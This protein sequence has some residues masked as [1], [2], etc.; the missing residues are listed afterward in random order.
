MVDCRFVGALL[1][2]LAAA[3][4]RAAD[5][6]SATATS[7][8]GVAPAQSV[9]KAAPE[10]AGPRPERIRRPVRETESMASDV[11]GCI[12]I[13]PINK[14]KP[15]M[16]AMLFVPRYY[17]PGRS[18]PLLVE[19]AE[20]G[21]LGRAARGFVEQAESRGFLILAMECSFIRQDAPGAEVVSRE[22]VWNREGGGIVS[23]LGR[24][25]AEFDKDL[26]VDSQAAVELVKQA[27]ARYNVARQGV[28]ITGFVGTALLAYR[29][30][31]EHPEVFRAV[32]ARTGD[33]E[34]VYM[35]GDIGRHI[36]TAIYI[37]YGAN[38][39][40]KYSDRAKA[41]ADYFKARRFKHVSIEE[42]PNSGVDYRPEIAANYFLGAF[43]ERAGPD[44]AAFDRF[45]NRAGLCLVGE[46]DPEAA[47]KDALP[48][49][50]PAQAL[51]A[52]DAFVEGHPQD[53]EFIPYCRFVSAR[54]LHEKLHDE[55]KAQ[56]RL[57]EFSKAPLAADPVA[58][59]ALLYLVDKVLGPATDRHD[60]LALLRQVLDRYTVRPEIAARAKE[61]IRQLA[62][63]T[64]P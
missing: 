9:G 64:K 1:I 41:A 23:T 54:L 63:E 47:P 21:D 57:R 53:K 14:T 49:I 50:D 43:N 30:A 62:P 17:D 58:P 20:P 56:E 60:S 52:L 4:V 31:G 35:P 32:I 12:N 2:L 19:A 36:D 26:A 6:G 38:E 7:A 5:S 44:R 15:P 55:A 29:Q 3:T 37:V 51:A 24:S 48:Q 61:L 46:P 34:P 59:E 33:F 8:A 45:T 42:I 16:R 13:F 39:L 18:W 27:E 25:P 22:K 28:A 40:F 11:A 10:P